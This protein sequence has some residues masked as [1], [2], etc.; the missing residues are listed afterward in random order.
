VQAINAGMDS[1]AMAFDT[2]GKPE[3]PREWQLP[4]RLIAV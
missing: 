1:N 4:V 2:T 3:D